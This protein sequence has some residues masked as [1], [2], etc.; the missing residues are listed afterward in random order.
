MIVRY[1]G[2]PTGVTYER[3]RRIREQVAADTLARS[4]ELT[5]AL[6]RA[7]THDL[8][9][10]LTAITTAAGGLGYAGLDAEERELLD[11]ISDQSAGMSRMIDDLLDLSR[12]R[13]GVLVPAADWT[14][15][16]D[17]AET[18]AAALPPADRDRVAVHAEPGLPL[19]AADDA[20]LERVVANLL[21]NAL[22]FSPAGAPVEIVVAHAPEGGV[23]ITVADRGP[24]IDPAETARL[25]EPFQRAARGGA[26]G[27]GLGLAIVDGLAR[28]NGWS[29]GFAPRPGGGTL[30]TVTL[31]AG[32]A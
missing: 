4:N 15:I 32:A 24:G 2:T 7:V 13:A 8:R 17:V 10:P 30:A 14:D 18:C 19:V 6:L 27:T 12:L 5:T 3:E 16:R 29:I 11:T 25:V 31:P 28:A 21:E 23:Q 1:T 22:K 26:P 20:H 9:S